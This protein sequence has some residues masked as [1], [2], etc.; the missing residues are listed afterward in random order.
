MRPRLIML[1][2]L[3][4]FSSLVAGAP[5]FAVEQE[6]GQPARPRTHARKPVPDAGPMS[7]ASASAK[8]SSLHGGDAK[9]ASANAKP[10]GGAPGAWTTM[11]DPAPVSSIGAAHI[12]P[13]VYAQSPEIVN[14]GGFAGCYAGLHGGGVLNSVT[15]KNPEPALSDFPQQSLNPQGVMAGVQ[16]G[17][18]LVSGAMLVGVEAEFSAPISAYGQD[19]KFR[20]TYY[21]LKNEFRGS[22]RPFFA[23]A[24][25]AGFI[26]DKALIYGKAGVA[27]MNASYT[28]NFEEATLNVNN[29]GSYTD[30]TSSNGQEW[31]SA[32]ERS[33][34]Q[35]KLSQFGFLLGFGVEYAIAPKWTLKGEYNFVYAGSSDVTFNQTGT[36][37]SY[38]RSMDTGVVK[39]VATTG[40]VRTKSAE[41]MRNILKVGVNRRF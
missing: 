36:G 35:A 15:I 12:A 41:S 29:G 20:N 27:F 3:I 2:P 32:Y 7:L 19:L 30:G 10:P 17:C 34:S 1:A 28:N 11:S 21:P 8:A 31:F 23:A 39:E 26:Q 38:T 40:Q 25:R 9:P 33:S 16:V 4:C 5:S 22:E 18:N 6:T 37:R 24:L 14:D 13:P